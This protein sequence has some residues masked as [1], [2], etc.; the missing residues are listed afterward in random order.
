M[1]K[2]EGLVVVGERHTKEAVLQDCNSYI[3]VIL[4]YPSSYPSSYY[5]R[6]VLKSYKTATPTS[7]SSYFWI[8]Q[9]TNVIREVF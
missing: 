9:A 8:V 2:E 1:V 4:D 6:S 3:K 5:K 7:R